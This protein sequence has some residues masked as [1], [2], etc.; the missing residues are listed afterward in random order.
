MP[1]RVRKHLVTRPCLLP[2][3]LP[4][5]SESKACNPPAAAQHTSYARSHRD[6]ADQARRAIVL[7]LP[8]HQA[9]VSSPTACVGMK[10][11]SLGRKPL[12]TSDASRACSTGL[13]SDRSPTRSRARC[14]M[15]GH[16]A[17]LGLQRYLSSRA[18]RYTHCRPSPSPHIHKYMGAAVG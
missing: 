6:A 13:P 7:S 2:R 4:S 8:H 9:T 5:H 12:V 16:Y 3:A 11:C 17:L 1:P 18:T 10:L 15:V 14:P